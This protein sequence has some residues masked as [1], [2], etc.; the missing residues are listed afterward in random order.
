M[1]PTVGTNAP[2][3]LPRTEV[4]EPRNYFRTRPAPRRDR[5]ALGSIFTRLCER[6]A[7]DLKARLRSTDGRDQT[8]FM[9]ISALS[10]ANSPCPRPQTTRLRS[11]AGLGQCLKR[12]ALERKLRLLGVRAGDIEQDGG[13]G[14]GGRRE[15]GGRYRCLRRMGRIYKWRVVASGMS[16]R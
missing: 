6:V 11:A 2:G 12:V 5:D 1:P 9:T 13:G 7:A 14:C 16:P 8:T 3:K 10:P 15:R 4:D